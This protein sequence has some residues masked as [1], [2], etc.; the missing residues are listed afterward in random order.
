MMTK[1]QGKDKARDKEKVHTLGY[2]AKPRDES[3]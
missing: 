3:K 1:A 2:E